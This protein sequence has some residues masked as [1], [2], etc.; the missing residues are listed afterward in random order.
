[1]KEVL[2][3]L[4]SVLTFAHFSVVLDETMEEE[5]IDRLEALC[6]EYSWPGEWSFRF[7][8]E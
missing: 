1:M 3:D 4:R 5:F 7:K 8:G 2:K 6:E